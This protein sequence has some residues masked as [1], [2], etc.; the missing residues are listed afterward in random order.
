[1]VKQVFHTARR[2]RRVVVRHQRAPALP[3]PRP[4]TANSAGR[5]DTA[6]SAGRPAPPWSGQRVRIEDLPAYLARWG[7][8]A[9]GGDPDLAGQPWRPRVYVVEV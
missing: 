8:K 2:R 9:V 1:M 3:S 4:D 7:L 5:P 6:N